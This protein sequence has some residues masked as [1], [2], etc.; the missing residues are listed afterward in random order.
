MAYLN[1]NGIYLA[2]PNPRP[3]GKPILFGLLSTY[4]GTAK[5]ATKEPKLAEVIQKEGKY[6]YCVKEKDTNNKN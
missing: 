5:Q 3:D 6:Y 1:Q 4:E 2:L